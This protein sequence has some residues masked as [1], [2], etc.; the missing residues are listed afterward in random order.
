MQT[1]L[2]SEN[3]HVTQTWYQSATRVTAAAQSSF[4]VSQYISLAEEL[5]MKLSGYVFDRAKDVKSSP[6]LGY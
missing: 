4:D 1:S 6:F 5:H 2:P 3:D